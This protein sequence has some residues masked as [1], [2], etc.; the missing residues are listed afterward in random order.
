[1]ATR[2]NRIAWVF[3]FAVAA[4]EGTFLHASAWQAELSP[5]VGRGR[6]SVG[7]ES[8]AV[9]GAAVGANYR[10]WDWGT[11]SVA[12]GLSL[13]NVNS[14]F[15]KNAGDAATVYN[16]RHLAVVGSLSLMGQET[17]FLGNVR[18]LLGVGA[19][20]GLTQ[21]KV[22]ENTPISYSELSYDNSQS[23][24]LEAR[25]GGQIAVTEALAVTAAY[26]WVLQRYRLSGEPSSAYQ[27]D[28]SAENGLSLSSGV[29]AGR[30]LPSGVITERIHALRF[31]LALQI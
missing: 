12:P 8:R 23:Q 17:P 11:I 30:Q 28:I 13:A 7:A 19:G 14:Y 4:L 31:G 16:A 6:S 10:A 20:L 22:T 24:M 15:R 27:E 18:P 1:M 29:P 9:G 26:A 2:I 25:L 21:V 3:L 5:F